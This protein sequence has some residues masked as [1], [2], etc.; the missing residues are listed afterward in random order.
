MRYGMVMAGGSGTRLWPLSRRERPKQLLPLLPDNRCLLEEAV[1]RLEGVVEVARRK[2]VMNCPLRTIRWAANQ[3][4]MM[5]MKTTLKSK[6]F[7]GLTC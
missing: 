4:S 3:P 2:H 6:P 7:D 1:D 5:T